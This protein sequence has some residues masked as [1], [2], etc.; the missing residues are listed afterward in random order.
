MVLIKIKQNE[1]N[2]PLVLVGSKTDLTDKREVSEEAGQTLAIQL[3]ARYRWFETSS[4]TGVGV[5]NL[6]S[7]VCSDL[8]NGKTTHL[9]IVSDMSNT[10]APANKIEA[11]VERDSEDGGKKRRRKSFL[12]RF[13]SRAVLRAAKVKKDE[14]DARNRKFWCF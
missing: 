12:Q 4:L 7:E 8:L 6:F 2:V 13:S 11:V 1:K 14:D 3:G 9:K 5:E 10:P